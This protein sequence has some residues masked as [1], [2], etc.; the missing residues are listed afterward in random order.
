MLSLT[1][2]T[3]CG[4]QAPPASELADEMI[5]TLE[6]VSDEAKE[7]MRQAVDDFRIAPESGFIDLDDVATKASEGQPQALELME[8]FEADLAACI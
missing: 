5:A 8:R 7:C 1:V 4:A 2:L 3:A 6:G